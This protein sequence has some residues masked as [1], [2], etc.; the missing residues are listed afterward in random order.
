M[1]DGIVLRTVRR[2]VGHAKFHAKMVR[3]LFEMIFENVAIGGV[4]PAAIE[5][6]QHSASVGIGRATMRFP[7][8]RDAVASESAGVMG[9]PQIQVPE[10]SLEVVESVRKD[11]PERGTGKIMVERLLGFLGVQTADAKQKAQEFLV[12]GVYADD[13]IRRIHELGSVVRDDL[14]LPIAGS[15]LSQR[16]GFASF[17]TAQTMSLQKLRDDG[18]ADAKAEGTKLVGDLSA[19]KIG[20]ENAVLIGI[21]GGAGIDDSQKSFVQAGK[22]RQAGAPTAPFFL[23][24]PTG[25]GEVGFRSSCKP[26][27]TVLRWQSK[28]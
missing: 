16:Q 21:A 19:G 6:E 7:P 8:I 23:A 14:E 12:F 1:L 26:R 28:S 24:W 4:A 2:I 3:Q 25:T 17:A 20:P 18:D 5:Q 9:Q 13:G 10:V 22:E 27:W 15:I 11:H